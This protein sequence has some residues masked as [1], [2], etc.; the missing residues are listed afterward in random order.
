M[1]VYILLNGF[2][3]HSHL[4]YASPTSQS[5]LLNRICFHCCAI[6][7]CLAHFSWF[8]RL[9]HS[10]F[11]AFLFFVIFHLF[12]FTYLH[13]HLSCEIIDRQWVF[14]YVRISMFMAFS[15]CLMVGSGMLYVIF[16]YALN[17]ENLLHLFVRDVLFSFRKSYNS[18]RIVPTHIL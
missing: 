18:F 5:V 2:M 13:Q 17:K 15:V 14:G 12:F 16:I 8:L 10:I 9:Y 1:Y 7:L 3:L 4:L 6:T 11:H